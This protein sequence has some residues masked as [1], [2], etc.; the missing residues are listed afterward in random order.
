MKNFFRKVAFGLKP[1]EKA[2]SDPLTWAQKQVETIPEL[3]WKGKYILSEKEMRKHWIKQRVTEETVFRKKYKNDPQGLRLAEKQLDNDSGREYWP[4]NEICMR[5]AEGVRS[6]NPVLAKLWYFWTNH[7]TISD[8]QSLP[9]FSTGAYQR[10]F[11]RANMDKQFET[12]AYE[13]TV[14]WPMI[15]HLDN[16]DNIG[17][18]S[19]SARQEWR[20]REKRPATLNEN[21]A[22]ELM[23]LHTISPKGGYTQEDVQELAK[24][25]TGWRPKWTKKSDQGTDV[26]FMSERHE[27][28]KKNVLGK[29]YKSG[30]KSLKIVIKDLAN[31]PSCREF[32]ATKL[33]RYLITDKPSKQMIDPIIKAWEQS[34]GYLPEVH[35]AAIKV[36]FENN[37]KY[38]KFQNPENWWLQTINMSGNSYAY[39]IPE[40]MMDKYQLGVLVSQTLREPDWLLENIGCHP[41]RSKQP[42]GYSDLST[43]WLS[44]ELIIRRLMYAKEA[45]HKYK[46]K[47]Q[48][49]DTI[50]EKIIR[51][52]FDNP[53]KILKIVSK[54]KSNEEKHMILF[55]LP[56]AL[57]A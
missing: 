39:P 35:K 2:P 34:D 23:E 4:N 37:E 9:G 43:D 29:T 24:I 44:T 46:I 5:H 40:K 7:F 8:T 17:P 27:P 28:G 21:H 3:N 42:N 10:E 51:T 20:I 33:C 13:G 56:E 30:R 16:K 22:R 32:I 57:R 50:H 15:M 53:D 55:N 49:D 38:K 47:D 25:M 41:Y 45:F 6:D 14:A 1:E 52:N 11:I 54:A 12:M 18:K 19:E 31:H 36:V 48:L 26:R